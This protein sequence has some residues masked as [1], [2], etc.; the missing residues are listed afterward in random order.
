MKCLRFKIQS[1]TLSK[2]N[3]M[4]DAI[5]RLFSVLLFIFACGL[6]LSLPVMLL[7][8][9]ALVPAVPGLAEIGWLQAWGIFVLCTILFRSSVSTKT[10]HALKSSV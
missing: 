7:W 1:S 3:M 9:W 4:T 6:L 10:R 8:N 5:A 2:A